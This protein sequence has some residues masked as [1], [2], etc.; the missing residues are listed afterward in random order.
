MRILV[1]TNVLLDYILLREPFTQDAQKIIDYCRRE[2]L[3]GAIAAHSV[4]DMFYILRK[5]ISV[6]ERR[7]I[8]LRLCDIFF[9]E[10]VDKDKL[11]RALINRDFS[12][13]ED[14]LQ[15]ECAASFKA[16]YIVTRNVEDYFASKIPCVTPKDFC[17]MLE[18]NE[19][20]G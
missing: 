13:F 2:I 7:R 16:D 20:E 17:T 11:T 3:N 15:Y 4:A 12:D 5:N 6:E 10:N 19:R 1:D 8:L 14:C 9:V 18:T